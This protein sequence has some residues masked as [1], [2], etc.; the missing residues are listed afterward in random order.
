MEWTALLFNGIP[1]ALL[2]DVARARVFSPMGRWRAWAVPS[3]AA[4]MRCTSARAG[5]VGWTGA[6]AWAAE[7]EISFL[8]S[9]NSCIFIQY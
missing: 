7:L 6:L 1:W 3:W 2:H 5:V 4:P 8:F 9:V